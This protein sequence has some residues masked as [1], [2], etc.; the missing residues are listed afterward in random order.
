SIGS[1]STFDV[2]HVRH[3]AEWHRRYGFKWISEHLS[4]VRVRTNATPDH[5]AGLALPLPWDREV[6]EMLCAR[7][8]HAQE[9]LGTSLLFE[10]GVV[11]TQVPDSDMSEAEFLNELCERTGCGVLLDLHNVHVNSVNFSTDPR[12]FVGE[13][14]LNHVREIHIA[15]GNRLYGVYL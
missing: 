6:L 9:I 3:L 5:H 8:I 15:G 7:V 11:H 13:L 4:A 10:N 1:G 12:R 14:N 2:E